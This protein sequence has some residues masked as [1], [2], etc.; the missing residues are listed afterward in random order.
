MG[1]RVFSETTYEGIGF[2]L[3]FS[4]MLDPVRAVVGSVGE[5][6]WGGAASTMFWVDPRRSW[7][8]CCSRSSSRP[9][10]IPPAGDEGAHL[11]GPDRLSRAGRP[12]FS[13]WPT[14]SDPD[15]SELT[16]FIHEQMPLCALLGVEALEMDPGGVRLRA[17]VAGRPVHG[18]RDVARRSADRPG[19]GR[20][21]VPGTSRGATG[22]STI[23]SKTNFLGAVR[24]GRV[25]AT[26]RPHVGSTTIVARPRC[27]TTPIASSRRSHRRRSCSGEEA[28]GRVV[29]SAT[30]ASASGDR[31]RS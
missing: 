2:G 18:G 16:A 19:L 10:P 31:R 21:R 6:A 13:P 4:V 7:S 29:S 24:Q 25:V 20:R 9:R 11:P 23:E 28:D 22:T 26:A 5:Y 14:Q 8:G 17:A 15:T 1:Q 3:G 27:G 30:R 12:C